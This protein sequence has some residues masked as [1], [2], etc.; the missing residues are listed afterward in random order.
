MRH[1]PRGLFVLLVCTPACAPEE[2]LVDGLFTPAEY[3]KVQALSPLMAPPDD[4]TN[5]WRDDPRAAAFGQK[6]FFETDYSGPLQIGDDGANGAAGKVGDTGKLACASCHAGPWLIDVRSQPGNVSLGSAILPR[7]AASLVNVAYYFPWI[8]NDGLLDSLWAESMIDIEFPLSFN[9]TR[10]RLAHV[11]Y[12]NHRDDYNAIFEPDLDPALD[13]AHPDAAR[14]PADAAVGS[15]EWMAMDP[16][17]QDHVTEIYV[18]FG[19]SIHAYLKLLVS[20]DAPFDRYVAGDTTALDASAKRGLKLFVGKAGCVECHNTPHFSDDDFHNTGIAAAGPNVTTEN[21]RFATVEFVLGHE[22]NS[23]SRWS[24][25]RTG[26]RLDGLTE[27][28]AL[29]GAWRTKGLRHVAETGPYMHTGQFAELRDVVEFYNQ[30]G[31]TDGIVGTKSELIVPLNLSD[32]EIDD[33][34][35]FLRSLTGEEVPAALLARP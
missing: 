22:F 13:P 7:N 33:I 4:P 30:G 9:S 26:D 1:L 19:K 20:K 15:P 24:D 17:D 14:F 11:V 8:E 25:D 32:A 12:A 27:D 29:K 2:D 23:V 16:A 21:G 10:S 31:H 3:E 18:N 34:V 28:E 5:K 6:L 35:A